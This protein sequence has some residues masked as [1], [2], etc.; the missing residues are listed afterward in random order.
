MPEYI[1]S[2]E[3]RIWAAKK[4]TENR[5]YAS[6]RTNSRRHHDT[7]LSHSSKDDELLAGV[8]SV[9][10]GH[11]AS[12]Y[13]DDGDACLPNPP[14]PETGAVLKNRIKESRRFVLFVTENSKDSTWIPWELGLGDGLKGDKSVALFPSVENAF[15]AKWSER[16][17]LGNY[18]RIVWGNLEGYEKPVWMVWNHHENKATRLSEWLKGY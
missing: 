5:E 2:G 18:R 9:L 12:V 10:E 4:L 3:L 7:F 13:T 11:G 6:A 1:T 15:E 16:E 17:Y 8:I 14:T